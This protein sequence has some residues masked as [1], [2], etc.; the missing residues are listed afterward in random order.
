MLSSFPASALGQ[1]YHPHIEE[2][3]AALAA[4][5]SWFG[6]ASPLLLL[7]CLRLRNTLVRLDRLALRWRQNRLRP[8]GKRIRV[9]D[10]RPSLPEDPANPRRTPGAQAWLI[11][12][13]QPLAQWRPRIELLLADPELVGLCQ[14]APQAGRLLRPL[15]RMWG[16]V[17]PPH[18][19]RRPAPRKPRPKQ[20]PPPPPPPFAQHSPDRWP[21]VPLRLRLRVPG[22]PVP[23]RRRRTP[24]AGD[25]PS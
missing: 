7:V 16:I 3:R 1:R 21:F 6:R 25:S 22:L 12:L 14:A 20:P 10:P 23:G 4:M 13:H 8:P 5:A 2:I 18:I 24:P 17:P 19:A 9:R 15:C 11:R